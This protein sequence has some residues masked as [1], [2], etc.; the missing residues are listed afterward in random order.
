M[1][2]K[3]EFII[4]KRSVE[5]NTKRL[6]CVFQYVGSVGKCVGEKCVVIS[7]PDDVPTLAVSCPVVSAEFLL[8]G[9]LRQN[10]DLHTYPCLTQHSHNSK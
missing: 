2:C 3:D 8:T 6:F 10:I 5:Q 7:C 4:V 1:S 9:I